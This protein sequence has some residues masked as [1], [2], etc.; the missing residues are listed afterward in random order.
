MEEQLRELVKNTVNKLYG[1][2]VEA[3]IIRPEEQF[4]DYMTNVA[5]KIS[6]QL[7]KTPMELA[8]ELVNKIKESNQLFSEVSV[9]GAGF[10]NFK[11][12][13]QV[14]VEVALSEP[15]KMLEGKVVVAEYSDPN[16]FKILHAGHLYTSV[17]G[18]SIANLLESSGAKVHRVNF[19]GDIGLHV[20]KTIW[21][22]LRDLGGENPEQLDKIA[23]ED[24]AQWLSNCY[25]K[26]TAGYEDDPKAEAE[27]KELNGRL[28]QIALTPDKESP[29]A[30]IYWATREWS[31]QS[32]E[33]FYK[34]INISFEKYYPESEVAELGIKTVRDHTPEVYT[35]SQGAV[36]F[37]GEKHG[38][39]SD[40]FINSQ[41]I[42]T[43]GAKDVGLIMR[44][45]EDYHYDKSV[46]ITGIEQ[47]GYMKVVLKSVEQFAPEMV[48][49]TVHL[50]H[51]LVKLAG[52]QKMSSRKGNI[53]R[54]SEILDLA[55]EATKAKKLNDDPRI[56]TGAVK[57]AFLK[58]SMGGDIVYDPS[59]SVSI[60]GNSGPYLQYAYARARSIL[61]KANQTDFDLRSVDDLTDHERSLIRKIGEFAETVDLAVKE[62]KP[63]HVAGYL[64]DL[65]QIFNRFYEN[66]RVIGD[67]R[68][69]LRLSLVSLYSLKLAE[70]L[71]LLG[72]EPIETV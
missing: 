13:L 24:R 56:T 43:Y 61:N 50:T 38:L 49:P 66:S 2:S 14:L 7:K 8:N 48:G 18:D 28:Y 20:A 33:D 17:I 46:I 27:I 30:R 39:Y 4:G 44:K 60:E 25:V 12:T 57:Y 54:A 64:Y 31:Y 35:E 19:G 32:F 42:P 23:Q 21:V 53:L 65:A 10:I 69:E 34:C 58:Q 71:R 5:F 70:G 41:G 11:L 45:W 55:S 68:Q 3:E 59:E 72:I 15:Q 67:E 51:G 36:I 37:A 40:V 16:P 6:S 26:G 22:V 47:A 63:H 62:I 29:L 1:L 9:A 52:G